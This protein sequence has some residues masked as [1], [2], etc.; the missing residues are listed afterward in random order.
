MAAIARAV[1]EDVVVAN[2]AFVL[3]EADLGLGDRLL[4]PEPR[5]HIGKRR[6]DL[7]MARA[8]QPETRQ[9]LGAE[10]VRPFALGGRVA[11]PVCKVID[12]GAAA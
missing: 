8:C 10:P 5:D 6:L 3:V 9:L 7:P 4:D 11:L 1:C 2:A 12:G